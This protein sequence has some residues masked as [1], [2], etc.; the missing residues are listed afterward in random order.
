MAQIREGRLQVHPAGHEVYY[1]LFGDGPETYLHI[2]GG[3]G[4]GHESDLPYGELAGGDL[5]VLLYDQ[6]GC[7]KSDQ[8]DDPSLWTIP[9]FIEEME[10]VRT[11]L[12]LGRIHLGGRSWGGVLVQQYALDHPEAL[13]S[14]T[15]SN[16]GP[17]MAKTSAGLQQR[18]MELPTEVYRRILSLQHGEEMSDEEVE[19]LFAEF[20]SRFLRRTTPYD[21]EKSKQEWKALFEEPIHKKLTKLQVFQ[22]LWGPDLTR[23]TGPMTQWDVTD[24]LHE[25][26]VPTLILCGWYD[27]CLPEHHFTLAEGIPNNEFVIFGNSSHMITHEKEGPAYMGVIKNFLERVMAG[28]V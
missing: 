14:L 4:G 24:R 12:N 2:H 17:S 19:D 28:S 16:M 6:L 13:K 20:F 15:I 10:A 22:T 23:C 27:E 7:G 5:Q 3:P 9:R 18:Y 8:P 21:P 1:K 26:M 25:I 11:G